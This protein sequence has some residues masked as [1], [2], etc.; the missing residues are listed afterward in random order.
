LTISKVIS[1]N[2]ASRVSSLV[3]NF[4]LVLAVSR[5]LGPVVKGET[6]LWITLIF[7]GVF[8]SN[9][10]GGF[11]LLNY[12]KNQSPTQA[13]L[14][15]YV[16]ALMAC[17][18]LSLVSGVLLHRSW[19]FILH[20]FLLSSFS[21]F[22]STHQSLLLNNQRYASF[23]M[24][25]F[26]Q[27]LIHFTVL[28]LFFY[29]LNWKNFHAFVVALYAAVL[30]HFGLSFTLVWKSKEG[31]VPFSLSVLR[32]LVANGFPFQL[33]ELLQLL[34]LRL[35]FFLL[36]EY[37]EGGL[38]RLGIYS[39]GISILESI[40]IFPRSVATVNFAETIKQPLPLNTMR[41]LRI[42]LVVSFAMLL[43]IFALPV[44]VYA[45][46]FGEGF[47]YVKYAVK[48]LFPGMGWYVLVLV[49]ASYYLAKKSYYLLYAVH[50]SGILVSVLF[51][52]LLI[53]RYEMSGAGLAATISFA[54]SA[55]FLLA[56]FLKTENISPKE[57]IPKRSDFVF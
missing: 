33:A 11:A 10:T 31:Y 41:W 15:A 55:T 49:L 26:F 29:V 18:G 35:Y 50:L 1:W 8:T 51:C 39:V 20:I 17:A 54:S 22:S 5:S 47:L 57:I 9:I 6:T 45:W 24:L 2:A 14:P 40:W 52:Y 16:W 56:Y 48:Y 13:L 42:S 21:S 43:V 44:Q 53:P 7:I 30:T 28:S 27:P 46:V 4:L 37:G 38:Y 32:N 34:H 19:Q 12:L 36:A 3:L 25:T 23:N